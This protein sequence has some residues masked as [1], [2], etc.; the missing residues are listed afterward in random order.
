MLCEM[1]N[2]YLSHE[3]GVIKDSLNVHVHTDTCAH[4]LP[5]ISNVFLLLYVKFY[6]YV[7]TYSVNGLLR[8]FF[9]RFSC[10][11]IHIYFPQH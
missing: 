11:L 6:E 4:T 10:I 9:Q 2:V 8:L 1:G 7:K 3:T 5:Q